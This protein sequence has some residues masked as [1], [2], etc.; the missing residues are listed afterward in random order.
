M[1][2][3]FGEIGRKVDDF[4]E[5]TTRADTQRWSGRVEEFIKNPERRKKMLGK[6]V[7]TI[8][9]LISSRSREQGIECNM[10]SK[11]THREAY[12]FDDYFFRPEKDRGEYFPI[13]V[14]VFPPET[15]FNPE[16]FDWQINAKDLS[17]LLNKEHPDVCHF[18]TNPTLTEDVNGTKILG[19]SEN[20]ITTHSFV[21]KNPDSSLNDL[22]SGGIVINDDDFEIVGFSELKNAA[23]SAPRV[24]QTLFVC[25]RD[26]WQEVAELPAYKDQPFE[27][28]FMGYF[29]DEHGE[30]RFFVAQTDFRASFAG[31]KQCL[32]AIDRVAIENSFPGWKATCLDIGGSFAGIYDENLPEPEREAG[33]NTRGRDFLMDTGHLQKTF[34]IFKWLKQ[35]ES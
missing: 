11:K 15:K 32:A 33:P 34:F 22:E 29:I 30:K 20:G 24:E 12:G 14:S 31:I 4:I 2:K 27:A 28:S 18:V 13:G 8:E 9:S 1:A 10:V 23:E 3:R 7:Q 25:G 6:L 35:K 26:N 17:G 5:K 16:E 21:D 19:F